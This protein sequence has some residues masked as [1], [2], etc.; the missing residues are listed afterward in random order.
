M[1]DKL[2]RLFKALTNESVKRLPYVLLVLLVLSVVQLVHISNQTAQNI[3]IATKNSVDNRNLLKQVAALSADNKRLA[4]QNN[5][6]A[7]E[8]TTH[9][10]CA[11]QLF[12]QY[13]RDL[14]PVV[15]LDLTTCFI[16][17]A[18]Q[19]DATP[20]QTSA[21]PSSVDP[22]VASSSDNS[23]PV[24]VNP[25]PDNSQP[26]TSDFLNRLLSGVLKLI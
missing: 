4:Q 8:N 7:K 18:A 9:Q 15:M 6:L 1:K 24:F 26:P 3:D 12:A 17:E 19:D 25:Q 10:D 5:R 2:V 13:T 14:R 21:Q 22:G 16:Q 23:T 11:A 20:G